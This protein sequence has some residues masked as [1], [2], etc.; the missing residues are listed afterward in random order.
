MWTFARLTVSFFLFALPFHGQTLDVTESLPTAIANGHV[1]VGFRSTGASSGDSIL[2]NIAK[3][4]AAPSGRL[5]ITIL[6]GLRLNNV[7]QTGQ[8]MVLAGVRGRAAAS[9]S[10]IPEHAI[11]LTGSEASTY[12]LSAFC[13]EFHKDNPAPT[14]TFAL[15][16]SDVK[17]GCILLTAARNNLPVEAT[18]AAVW[19]YTDN[20][21]SQGV[22]RKF[23]LSDS[24]WS[25]A[26]SVASSCVPQNEQPTTPMRSITPRTSLPEASS[27]NASSEAWATALTMSTGHLDLA[28]N[29]VRF[30][31]KLNKKG[32]LVGMYPS[33]NVPCSEIAEWKADTGNWMNK[34]PPTSSCYWFHIKL[35]T[36][37]IKNYPFGCLSESDMKSVLQKI[38]SSC[39]TNN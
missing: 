33:F 15:G 9:G 2:L 5:I 8:S 10:F 28:P 19:I 34:F 4:S 22:N 30:E 3:T 36:G 25:A 12:V 1:I 17:L 38:S 26:Q 23:S 11:V 20:V 31:A 7:S 24:D 32:K 18:Q 27:G 16:L 21:S 35:K 13:A 29:R 37:K 39:G 14:S 6:P